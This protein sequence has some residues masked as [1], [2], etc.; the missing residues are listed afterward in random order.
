MAT[1]QQLG[2]ALSEIQAKTQ[3]IYRSIRQ[4][5][6]RLTIRLL[7]GTLHSLSLLLDDFADEAALSAS[8]NHSLFDALAGALDELS[9]IHSEE[10]SCGQDGASELAGVASEIRQIQGQLNTALQT[11]SWAALLVCLATTGPRKRSRKQRLDTTPGSIPGSLDAAADDSDS[12]GCAAAQECLKVL[13]SPEFDHKLDDCYSHRF[14]VAERD[15]A[16]PQY[17]SCAKRVPEIARWHYSFVDTDLELLFHPRKSTNFQ[18]WLMEYARQEWPEHFNL[19]SGALSM[20]SFLRLMSTVSD[21]SL[22]TL[23]VAAAMGLHRLCNYLILREK[24][25]VNQPSPLGTPLY[26]A[27]LGPTA[28]LGRVDDPMQL[29][30]NCK[31]CSSFQKNTIDALLDAGASCTAESVGPHRDEEFS[32]ATLAFLSSQSLQDS[33]I[34]LRILRSGASLDERFV[35]LFHGKDSLLQYWPSPLPPPTHS[36]LKGALPVILDHAVPRYD[37]YNDISLLVTGVYDIIDHLDLDNP[38]S[39]RGSRPLEASDAAYMDLVRDAVEDCEVAVVRRLILDPRWSPNIPISRSRSLSTGSSDSDVSS[40]LPPKGPTILHYAV[41]ADDASLVAAI[42]E[43]GEDVNV[44]VRNNNDQTPLMLSESPEVFKLLLDHGARTTDTDECG[45][46]IWH[47]AAANSDLALLDCL[48]E[49]DEHKDENLKGLMK[50]GQTPIAQAIIYPFSQMKKQR[51]PTIKAPVG[52]LHMLKICQPDDEYLKSPTPLIFLAVEWGSDE[53][54]CSLIDFGADPLLIDDKGR[55]ATHFLNV[56]ASESLVKR[57]QDFNK[58]PGLTFEGLSPAETIFSTFNETALLAPQPGRATNHPANSK[59]L[60]AAAYDCLLSEVILDYR[61][62]T[63]AGLWE[64]FAKTVLTGWARD[65]PAGSMAGPSMLV[66]VDCLIEKKALAKYEEERQQC[67][68]IPIFSGWTLKHLAR[69]SRPPWLVPMVSKILQASA[70]GD[71][72]KESTD[73]ALSLKIAVDQNHNTLVDILLGLGVSVHTRVANVSALEAACLP[74]SCDSSM[75]DKVLAHADASKMNDV[76][77]S[78]IGL[79]FRLIDSRVSYRDYKL[80]AL[81]RKGCDPNVTTPS[82]MPMVVAY[83]REQQTHAA[84]LLLDA[85]ADPS[86]SWISGLDTALVAAAKGD[87]IILTKIMSTRP[88][89]DWAKRCAFEFS[90]ADLTSLP[91]KRRMRNCTALH[92]G[93]AFGHGHVLKFYINSIQIDVEAATDEGWRPLHFAAAHRS[94]NGSCARILIENGADPAAK[95]HSNHCNPLMLAVQTYRVEAVRPLLELDPKTLS[96]I[97]IAGAFALALR[98]GSDELVRLFSPF[99]MEILTWSRDMKG[100]RGCLSDVIGGVLEL[101][102]KD[103]DHESCERVLQMVDPDVLNSIRMSCGKCSPIVLAAIQGRFRIGNEASVKMME[104]LI[105]NGADVDMPDGEQYITPLHEAARQNFIYG[106]KLLLEKGANPNLRNSQFY[107]PLTFAVEQGYLEMAK[108]LV[109]YGADIHVYDSDGMSI[110]NTC[111]EESKCP[112]MFI[113]LMSLGLDPYRHDKAG[114]TPVH[115]IILSNEFSGIAFNHGFDFSKVGEIR[116]GFVSLIIEF[117]HNKANGILLRL[118]KRLPFEEASEL[119]NSTPEAFVSPLCN[120]VIRDE[121]EC[122]PTLL[123]YGADIDAEGSTDGSALMIAC[124]KGRLDVVEVLVRHGA[125]ISY[126]TVVDGSPVFRNALEYVRSFPH[127]VRWLLVDRFTRQGKIEGV[128]RAADGQEARP[129]S[130]PCVAG[131]ELSGIGNHTGRRIGESGLDFV[132]RMDQIRRSLR[133]Q[134][135]HIVALERN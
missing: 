126:H 62:V 28:L 12:S 59:A 24:Q 61:D 92:L 40:S 15:V 88:D 47:F 41:E 72:F 83:V 32:L 68:L 60:D 132:R 130:G 125:R 25:D 50:D 65:W 113:W 23:H 95:I 117:N 121:L 103:D 100:G 73:A 84:L 86:A 70:K 116:K 87:L 98:F 134:T 19:T 26:C 42:L 115:D 127:I 75:F 108:L 89:F 20:S 67:C 69:E 93:A 10:S 31:P 7:S 57:L 46:N 17:A 82:G 124:L 3:S 133:G 71:S 90:P 30:A 54:L 39:V 94:S 43:S 36:F 4:S 114:Y 110:L 16:H 34:L 48:Q 29:I 97:D 33:K 106:A 129:W 52:A 118:F 85:G 22:S 123:R 77:A 2:Q 13:L 109:E 38:S 74:H 112:K 55:T 44:H 99:L 45:R 35:Q 120:A 81:L 105:A 5:D 53:L 76:N 102:M 135:V 91:A 58:D 9:L 27:L 122:I 96:H 1:A 101:L 111:G 21:D 107:T 64:R 119:A 104:I 79:L 6:T 8:L 80:S 66:A 14:F 11:N 56:S 51:K 128:L 131:Y 49:N 78:R 18:Q 37:R 63:G